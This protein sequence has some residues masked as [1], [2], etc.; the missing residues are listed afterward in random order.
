MF[1]CMKTKMGKNLIFAAASTALLMV[2]LTGASTNIGQI[3][4]TWNY[5]SNAVMQADAGGNPFSFIIYGTNQIGPQ[6]WPALTNQIWTNY[7]IVGYDGSNYVF[8]MPYQIQPPGEFYF[9]ATVS[10]NI[11]GE[12]GFSNTSSTPSLP[13]PITTQIHPN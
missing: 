8:S 12:S 1:N 6:P 11:W 10:N 13:I 5:N 2:F 7:P 3:H 4:L 9:E